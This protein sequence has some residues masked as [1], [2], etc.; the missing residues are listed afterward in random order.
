[1]SFTRSEPGPNLGFVHHT[2]SFDVL[3]RL[4]DS[5]EQFG[6]LLGTH[7]AIHD[8]EFDLCP[9]GQLSRFVDHVAAIFDA[10]L[11][12]VHRA[13]LACRFATTHKLFVLRRT[14]V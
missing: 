9:L 10:G 11:Q 5:Q 1:L 4:F 8:H 7:P 3:L 13:S 14:A 12:G 2:S 6:S